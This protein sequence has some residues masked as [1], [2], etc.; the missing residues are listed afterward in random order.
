VTRRRSRASGALDPDRSRSFPILPAVVGLLLV[1]VLAACGSSATT[2]VPESIAPVTPSAGPSSA[3]PSDEPSEAPSDEPS[4]EPSEVPSDEPSTSPSGGGGGDASACTGNEGNRDF[5]A[6]I[7]EAVDWPVYC[8]VLPDRWFVDTGSYSL[9]RGGHLEIAYR[10]PGG[11]RLELQ[12]GAFC[13]EGETGCLPPGADVGPASFGDMEGTLVAIDD[14]SYAV[15]VG[16]GEAPTW[17]ARISGTDEATARE[18]AA[19]L[20]LVG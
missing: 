16:S 6:S 15:V 19:A 17:V 4:D 20:A 14:G 10:G 12:E 5:F 13:E 1:L 18:I 9:R 11:A 7:A 8:A 3:S 2:D